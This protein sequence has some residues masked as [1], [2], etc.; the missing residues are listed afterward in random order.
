MKPSPKQQEHMDL[1]ARYG[2]HNYKPLPVVLNKGKGTKVFDVDGNE[3]YDFLSA[4]SAVNQGHC[5][6]KI[7]DAL[8]DQANTLC[9]TSRAFYNDCL[10]EY[11][12][13]VTDLFGYDKLLPMN[14]GAEAVETA[15]KLARK[16]AYEVKGVAPDQAK[17]VCCEDNFHGRTISIVS[18]ST[19]PDA[20]GNFGPFVPG[21][22][23]IPYNDVEA[24]EKV[25]QEDGEEVCAFLVE[26]IQGEAGVVVPDEGY[27]T[28]CYDLCKKHN[29]L[30][31]ADEVQ[32]GIARTGKML[33]CEHEGVRPDIVILG[34]ALSGGV[35]PVSA[36]LADDDIMMTI[37]PGQHGSTYGGNPIAC[38]VGMAALQVV[39][40]EDLCER[41]TVLGER[42][43]QG[44]L[45]MNDENIELVRGKGLLNAAVIRAHDGK[46][47]WD[48][49]LLMAKHGVLAKQTHQ[50]IVRFAP[51]LVITEEELD[52]ALERIKRAFAEYA[53]K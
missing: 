36:V 15:K 47:A 32:T 45:E 29:V 46:E 44:L 37:R 24:L 35:F 53:K 16:W 19:D 8:V 17:I 4:Y 42:F 51:P 3:Y 30:F 9:L 49:C 6:Q 2:A 25:L 28:A 13:Y 26:P 39:I 41:A 10:G 11:E 22:I 1:E 31:V 33:A 21:I 20:Y 50:H 12:K 43:R 38:K 5:H 23:K 48:L 7:V 14:S 40:D 27:L 52:D 18:M 34:K